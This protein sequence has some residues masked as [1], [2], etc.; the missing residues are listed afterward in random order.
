MRFK[1]FVT[2]LFGVFAFTLCNSQASKTTAVTATATP[3][4]SGMSFDDYLNHIKGSGKLV[5][6]DFSA[7]WCGPCKTLKPLVHQA[8][9]KNS[10][11]VELFEIDV[12]QNPVV[13]STMQVKGIPLL[14]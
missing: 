1:L 3:P 13:S 10:D 6:V 11:K 9:K 2:F 7:V 12:D 14:I 8:V 4:K 5:L